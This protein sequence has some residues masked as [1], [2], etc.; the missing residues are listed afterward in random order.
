MSTLA[1]TI[2]RQLTPLVGLRLAVARRAADLRVLHF[3]QMHVVDRGSVG[4]Y[5]LHIQC[6]WRL[7]GS[8]GIVTGRSDLWEPIEPLH[9]GDLEAWR[10]EHGNLQDL[11]IQ[12]CLGGQ[13]PTTG[14]SANAGSLLVVE[15][16]AGD[17]F[18]GAELRMSGGYRLVLFPDG[19]RGEDWRLFDPNTDDP[20]F[21]IWG[22]KIE[23]RQ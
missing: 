6:P 17:N 11:R 15:S 9:G 16:V 20:H 21:V 8:T 22:G 13:D 7:E 12:G 19:S 2:G 3:G 14:S 1:E 4:D 23:T 10:Y 18:G 5:A